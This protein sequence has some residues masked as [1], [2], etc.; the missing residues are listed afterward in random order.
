MRRS[1]GRFPLAVAAAHGD[2]LPGLHELE[3]HVVDDARGQVEAFADLVRRQRPAPVA[4]IPHD[5][6][7]HREQHLAPL[8]V[9]DQERFA[10]L[11]E[12]RDILIG[13]RQLAAEKEYL[14]RGLHPDQQ[15]RQGREPA[16]DGVVRGHP[17]L[18]VDV[19]PLEEQKNRPGDD[20]GHQGAA[21]THSGVGYDDVE[22]GEHHPDDDHRGKVRQ[23]VEIPAVVESEQ[24]L[25]IVAHGVGHDPEDRHD[26][27]HGDVVGPLAGDA[28]L[29]L[30]LPDVV[31]GAF[32]R[33]EDPDHGPEK[34]DQRHG[35]H[36]AALRTCQ[37]VFG[38]VDD[39]V[40][41]VGV[42]GEETVEVFDQSVGQPESF[43]HGEYHRENR[44]QRHQR[45]ERE[46]RRTDDG[47]VFEQAAGRVEQ[48][49]VLLHEPP[50]DGVAPFGDVAPENRV[51]EVCQ[52]IAEFH[53]SQPGNQANVAILNG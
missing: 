7:H 37:G 5:G 38:E 33:P 1:E 34:H 16:V 47:S 3:Q 13:E 29:D 28:A 35:G 19:A 9:A 20:A 53:K 6:E 4:E 44:H 23:Q 39:V 43:H 49:A 31:E 27:H 14:P 40:D 22:E 10:L 17:P 15:Q 50:H 30:D 18:H 36:H 46:R 26:H 51:G 45:V 8:V 24:L 21:E 11:A 42:S 52:K 32:D 41:N 48:Q 25:G 12:T 2:Q